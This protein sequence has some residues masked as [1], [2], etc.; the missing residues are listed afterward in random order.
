[1]QPNAL[2]HKLTVRLQA[3]WGCNRKPHLMGQPWLEQPNETT[4]K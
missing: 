2:S 1:M 3:H 4:P